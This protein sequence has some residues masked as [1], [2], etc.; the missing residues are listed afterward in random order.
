M[1]TSKYS[2]R[3]VS[4]EIWTCE[5]KASRLWSDRKVLDKTLGEGLKVYVVV[6][7]LALELQTRI[8]GKEKVGQEV[9]PRFLTWQNWSQS[10]GQSNL[11][12]CK[13]ASGAEIASE[14]LL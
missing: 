13:L 8:K 14:F 5:L 7:L 10:Y 3:R 4:V 2:L 11:I 12:P 9:K 6:I 1:K